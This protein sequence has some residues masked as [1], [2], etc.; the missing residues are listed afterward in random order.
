[1]RRIFTFSFIAAALVAVSFKSF[2]QTCAVSTTS[3]NPNPPLGQTLAINSGNGFS[4]PASPSNVHQTTLGTW[5]KGDADQLSSP[6]YFY[7]STQNGVYFKYNLSLPSTGSVAPSYTI[8]LIYG[9]GGSQSVSCSGT[10]GSTTPISSTVTSYYFSITGI[11]LPA[12]TNFR[13]ILSLATTNSD[14][15]INGSAFQANAILAPAGAV[16][17]VKFSGLDA[18][19]AN[20]IVSLNWKIATE[21]NV[22]GYEIEKSVDGNNYSKI[23]FVN[24]SGQS[25][26]TFMDSKPGSIS[27]YRIKSVDVNGRY[28]YSTVALV[29][30]GKSIIVLKAFPSPFVKSLSIQHPTAVGRSL[31]TISSEDGRTIKSVT[32]VAGTQQTDVDLSSAKPGMY[33]IR[34]S[35]GNGGNETLKVLKQQ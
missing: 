12:S 14:K 23:G 28:T 3:P 24:A 13:I 16:L 11:T 29:K 27:Y 1:M 18:K 8:T 32:P 17:P 30:A 6:I 26:Y 5:D 2:A 34:F 7:N 22:N 25:S 33:L 10:W 4:T 31:I 20:S 21:E 15:D 35:D 9:T 19:V